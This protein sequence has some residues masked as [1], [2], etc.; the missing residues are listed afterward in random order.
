[1]KT[2]CFLLFAITMVFLVSQAWGVEWKSFAEHQ[3]FADKIYYDVDSIVY[4]TKDII[5]VWIK[6]IY[7]DEGRK[8]YI[9]E[10][11]SH[12]L[13]TEGYDE[14]EYELSLYEINCQMRESRNLKIIQMSINKSMLLNYDVSKDQ[15]KFEPIVPTSLMDLL[16]QAVCKLQ[17]KETKKKK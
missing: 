2:I 5:S 6:Q 11:I 15:K 13:S 16:H 4:P 1:M 14:L 9:S 7:T 3:R 12:K 17:P 10:R 8:H